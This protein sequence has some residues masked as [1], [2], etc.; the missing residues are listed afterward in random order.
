MRYFFHIAL[1]G[2]VLKDSN[3]EDLPSMNDVQCSAIDMAAEL[4]RELGTPA[5]A[6]TGYYIEVMDESGRCVF[7]LPIYREHLGPMET[8]LR[9]TA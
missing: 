1:N 2:D 6:R 4:E 9:R 5:G 8:R 7:A 3:G